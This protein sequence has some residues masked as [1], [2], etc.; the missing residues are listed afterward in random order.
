MSFFIKTAFAIQGPLWFH[1]NFRIA[2]YLSVKKFLKKFDNFDTYIYMYMYMA[3]GSMDILTILILIY[4][5]CLSFH[6][7]VSS[8]SLIYLLIVF[9]GQ[10]FHLL[11]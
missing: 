10:I 11:G 8:I 3:L 1:M 7:F 9:D 2:S 4:E 5:H 6:L